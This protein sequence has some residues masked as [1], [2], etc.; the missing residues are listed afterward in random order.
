MNT[1]P[2]SDMPLFETCQPFQAI[3]ADV[4]SFR[5]LHPKK[6]SPCCWNP[7]WL[8]A[9]RKAKTEH[10][11]N[12]API[13][14]KVNIFT[15]NWQKKMK[16]TKLPLFPTNSV[17]LIFPDTQYVLIISPKYSMIPPAWLVKFQCLMVTPTIFPF[18][19]HDIS[20]LDHYFHLKS[21]WLVGLLVCNPINM[22]V[23]F[24]IVMENPGL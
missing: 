1:W 10:L 24:N 23:W 4:A 2:T 5:A 7:C 21:S 19:H 14:H 20:S 13:P 18:Y 6:F 9:Q 12:N 11:W 22:L 16:F 17:Q 15:P 8:E 3:Q